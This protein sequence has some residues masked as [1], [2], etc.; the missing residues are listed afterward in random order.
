M[1]EK[2]R[3]LEEAVKA[4]ILTGIDSDWIWDGAQEVRI[5]V[6]E[7]HVALPNVMQVIETYL[8]DRLKETQTNT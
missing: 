7:I 1:L 6:F 5:N 3:E 8:S 4:A 2:R